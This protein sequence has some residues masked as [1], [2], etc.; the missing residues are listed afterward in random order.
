MEIQSLYCAEMKIIIVVLSWRKERPEEVK[1]WEKEDE[2]G[3]ERTARKQRE[4]DRGVKAFSLLGR[5]LTSGY[6]Y[7]CGLVVRAHPASSAVITLR[8]PN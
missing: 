1:R 3:R 4:I 7:Q 5:S 6:V 2:R 8:F